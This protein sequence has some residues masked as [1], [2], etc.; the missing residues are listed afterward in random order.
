MSNTIVLISFYSPKSLG[1]RY[2][3]NALKRSGFEVETVFFKSYN[4]IKPKLPTE[5]EYGILLDFIKKADPL[6]IGLSVMASPYMEVVYE[7]NARLKKSFSVPV[8]WGGVYAS[9]S[10]EECMEYADYVTRGEGEGVMA[11]LASAVK[12]GTDVTEI[13]NLV[14]KDADGKVV[15]NPLRPLLQDLD[16]YG[17]PGIG[18]KNKHLIDNDTMV[19]G[20][21]QVTSYSYEMSCSRGCPFVCSY[22]CSVAVMRMNKGGGKYVRF[23]EV[24]NVIEELKQAK[25]NMKKLKVIHFWDEIFSDDPEWIDRF[26]KRYKKEIRLPFEVWAHPLKTNTELI[27]K[28]R[29]AGLYKV[30]MG[31]QSGSYHIRKE[32]F[33]RP[34]K[35]ESIF[36]C[37]DIFHNEKVPQLIYDLMLRHP[38]ETAETIKETYEM[39]VNFKLPFELQLHGLSFL[40]GADIVDKAIEMKLVTPEA[41]RELMHAPIQKQFDYHW[42]FENSDG[43]INYWYDLIFL[44]QFKSMRKAV[45]ELAKDDLSPEN[46]KRA[47]ELVKKGGKL[48]RARYWRHKAAIVL[49]GTLKIT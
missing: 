8:V 23:R 20:D 5:T 40:P 30:V 28:L 44:T 39:C 21:P 46:R 36:K 2:L 14:Y 32:I 16:A 42:K 41:M 26:V 27:R 6:M 33:H 43:R 22:C 1:L 48:A 7:L 3:E 24:D 25:K 4:S 34:E 15:I 17:I 37:D 9:I 10:P 13:Q 38:F 31:I 47:A 35:N 11:E 45:L 49:K 29:S 19:D 12:N 18:G